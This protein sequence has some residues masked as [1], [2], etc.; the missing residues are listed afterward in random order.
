MKLL[1]PLSVV[2]LVAVIALAGPRARADQTTDGAVRFIESL[3]DKAISDLT[4]NNLSVEE[5]ETRFRALLH[6][7]FDM[8]AINRFVLGRYWRVATE[9][10]KAEFAHL[11]EEFLVK[12]YAV[13][14][15]GYS[16]ES[17]EVLGGGEHPAMS[18]SNA[19]H[20]R[21]AVAGWR[22]TTIAATDFAPLVRL[23]DLPACRHRP[24]Y[25]RP[26][27]SVA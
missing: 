12:S 1:R 20:H 8:P 5:R 16:G 3:G 11:F 13:R 15:A 2:L 24:A 19:M 18:P 23:P 6:E 21:W 25:P 9:E 27:I 10:E 26:P 14:F 22:A 7:H 17:F 4:G